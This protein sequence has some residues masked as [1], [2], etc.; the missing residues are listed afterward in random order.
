M[1]SNLFTIHHEAQ[2]AAIITRFAQVPIAVMFTSNL[3]RSC[4]DA[5]DRFTKL[6]SNKKV[7]FVIVIVDPAQWG[8]QLDWDYT[9]MVL[10]HFAFYFTGHIFAQVDGTRESDIYQVLN[11]YL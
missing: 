8:S 6:A 4:R 9:P 2:L 3:S 10:P 5:K 7:I 11:A 1:D